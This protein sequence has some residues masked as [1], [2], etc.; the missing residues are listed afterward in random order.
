MGLKR[1]IWRRTAV[2]RVIDTAKNIIDER[3]AVK[4]ISRTFKE[5]ICEDNP[6]TAPIYTLG[7]Y[8]GKVGGYCEASQKYEC[9]LIQQAEKFLAQQKIFEEQRDAY[10]K[11]LD[12]YEKEI[13]ALEF[14]TVRT[15][16]ENQYLTQL[17][18]KER[19]LLTLH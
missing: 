19:Q 9:K 7:K 14:K 2:G 18:L 8:D 1:F 11:L 10:E 3:S 17:L 12:E 4:G 16:E 13:H 6:L 15:E 5:D